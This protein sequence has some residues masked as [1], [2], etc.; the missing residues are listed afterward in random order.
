MK[1]EEEERS[2]NIEEIKMRNHFFQ[3]KIKIYITLSLSHVHVQSIYGALLIQ[4]HFELQTQI[5]IGLM[6]SE[7]RTRWMI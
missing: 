3:S 4:G 6:N 1:E 2:K 5:G 7:N